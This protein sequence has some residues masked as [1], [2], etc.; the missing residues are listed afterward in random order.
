MEVELNCVNVLVK[1]YYQKVK[2]DSCNPVWY[3]EVPLA[4]M[5]TTIKDNVGVDVRELAQT[6]LTLVIVAEI[7][8]LVGVEVPLS[9][10]RVLVNGV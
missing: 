4:V 10:D 5:E 6:I 3:A 2:V 9:S 7:M 8:V 1:M